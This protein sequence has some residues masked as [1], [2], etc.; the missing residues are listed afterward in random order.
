MVG[1]VDAAKDLV[2]RAEFW[3]RF[4]VQLVLRG[5]WTGDL[6]CVTT[7]GNYLATFRVAAGLNIL[8]KSGGAPPQSK[9]LR[10]CSNKE[11]RPK[12]IIFSNRRRGL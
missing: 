3:H 12:E 1:F 2:R 11:D 4:G 8:C 6:R 7:C 10:D 9:T 5:I